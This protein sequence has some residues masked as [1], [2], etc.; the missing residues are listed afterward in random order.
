MKSYLRFLSRNKL[1]AAIEVVGLSLALALVIVLSSHIVDDISINKELKNTDDIYLVHGAGMTNCFDE[2][3]SLYELMPEIETSCGMVQSGRRTSLFGDLTTASYAENQINV[4]VMGVSDTFFDLFTFSLSAGNPKDVLTSKNSVV[5][6]EKM[7]NT[8][9]PNGDALGK[10]INVYENNQMRTYDPSFADF[11][12]NLTVTG[13]FPPF[14]KTVFVEP[15]MIMRYDLIIEQQQ[16]MFQG[17]MRIGECSFV[18]LAEGTDVRKLE[19]T[20]TTEFQKIAKSRYPKDVDMAIALTTFDEIKRQ[21]PNVFD[22]VFDNIRHGKLFNVYLLMCVFVTL[23]SLI[24]YIVLTT[25][26]GKFRIK[27]IAMRQLLGVSR[28][29]VICRCFAEAF[30]LLAV[31]CVLAVII[32]VTFKDPIG[33]ILS[34]EI[35]PMSQLSEYVILAVVILIMVTMASAVPSFI[36]SSYSAVN[37]IKGEVRYRDKVT[38]GKWLIGFAGFLSIAALSICFGV[39]HQTRHLIDQPLGYNV[40]DIV[41]VVF[42]GDD[43]DVIYDKLKSESYVEKIGM[44]GSLPA[45]M[46]SK[47]SIQNGHGEWEDVY[48]IDGTDEAREILGIEILE[49]FNV[50]SEDPE[51]G[52]WYMCQSTY[53][54]GSEYVQDGNLRM[55]RHTPLSGIVSDYKIGSLKA[56]SRGKLTCFNVV[57]IESLFDWGGCHVVKV[58]IDENAAKQKIDAMLE[59]M[60]DSK[61]L[62]RVSTLR[63]DVEVDVKEDKNMLKLLVLFSSIC[64]LMTIMTIVGLSSYHSKITEKDN[65]V[66]NVF[67][68]SKIEMIRRIVMNFALPVAISAA[69]AIPVA[70]MVVD[71]WLEGYV[72]RT[73]NSPL[74]YG[75][76]FAV[77]L[78]VVILSVI[79]QIL[80]TINICPVKSLKKE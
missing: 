5:I 40:D 28:R 67:G 44:L 23:V 26:F 11:N 38:F 77:V 3:P 7:A 51:D 8:L 68:C 72:I 12:V 29:G 24:D 55:Y 13:I 63:E 17:S 15:D 21:D 58:N 9:F 19:A 18:K 74:I 45:S 20:L 78:S 47:T 48:F 53:E 70:Y 66:R 52:K 76:A 75:G 39:S 65:A 6:S 16:S 59:S 50:A 32:A 46:Y 10:V 61:D 33:Q 69:F 41:Y 34:A 73:N 4:A 25:A 22:Y 71:R 54:M 42:G 43:P 14:S 64:I 1:Y 2:V 79:V 56:D 80:R 62:Y 60:G 49:D 36:L 57:D 27:E 30:L 37:V 31:S 35:N